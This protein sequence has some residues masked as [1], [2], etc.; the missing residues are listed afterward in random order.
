MPPEPHHPRKWRVPKGTLI[1]C[2]RP[3]RSLGPDEPK[4]EKTVILKWVKGLK[5]PAGSVIVSLLGRKPDGMSEYSFY[6]FRGGFDPPSKEPLF[7]DWL[8]KE[9][10]DLN[11]VVH[12][13]PTVDFT[14]IEKQKYEAVAAAINAA[15]DAGKTVVLVDSGGEQRTK[16]VCEYMGL[17]ERFG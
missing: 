3:G 14:A 4:V 7:Q 17:V 15:L 13:H 10:P 6:P 16:H 9:F 1:T 11:L 8:A 2:G 5:L 12:D